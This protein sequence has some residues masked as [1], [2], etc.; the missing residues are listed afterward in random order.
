MIFGY[1]KILWFICKHLYEKALERSSVHSIST[2][3]EE[4]SIAINLLHLLEDL[5]NGDSFIIEIEDSLEVSDVDHF[6]PD[7]LV[8]IEHDEEQQLVEN[9]QFSLEYM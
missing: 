2:T 8:E 9:R 7:Y 5:C 4:I 1:Q 3:E 6:D